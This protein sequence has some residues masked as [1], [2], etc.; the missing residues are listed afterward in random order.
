[1]FW[2]P[3]S[4]AQVFSGEILRRLEAR[5]SEDTVESGLYMASIA[6][7]ARL[8]VGHLHPNRQRARYSKRVR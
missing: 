4:A 8:A 7:Q 5:K 3:P 2:N 1:M 6:K